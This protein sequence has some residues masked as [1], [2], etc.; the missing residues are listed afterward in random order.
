MNRLAIPAL[1][2]LAACGGVSDSTELNAITEDDAAKLCEE[3]VND[4]PGRTIT[5][6]FEGMSFDIDIGLFDD[7]DA[8]V[9][10]FEPA[11]ESCEATVGDVRDC[12]E[13]FASVAQDDICD[14]EFEMETPASCQ[15]MFDC[16]E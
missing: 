7:V 13:T 8:C 6:E 12:M 11:P 3:F 9:R 14:P 1:L 16:Y 2:V 10:D 5:C 15:A 4:F